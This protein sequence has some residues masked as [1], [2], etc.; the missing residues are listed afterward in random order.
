M[1][2]SI[3]LE[4]VGIDVLQYKRTSTISAD[5]KLCLLKAILQRKGGGP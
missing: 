2:H 1:L 4:S 5:G 3:Q